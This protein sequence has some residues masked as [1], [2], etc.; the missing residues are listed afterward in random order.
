MTSRL[1]AMCGDSTFFHAAMPGLINAQHHRANVIDGYSRQQRYG[2][3]RL[4]APSR[5]RKERHGRNRRTVDIEGVCRAIG[6]KVEVT[7]PFD[8]EGTREKVLKALEDPCGR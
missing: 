8:F 7:D 6:A 3:D 4:P 2:H 5:D 1:V